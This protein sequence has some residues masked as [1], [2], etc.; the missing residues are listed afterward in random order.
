MVYLYR[1]CVSSKTLRIQRVTHPLGGT[2][3]LLEVVPIPFPRTLAMLFITCFIKRLRVI[4]SAWCLWKRSFPKNEG[5]KSSWGHLF[6]SSQVFSWNDSL[7][8]WVGLPDGQEKVSSTT[9]TE[10]LPPGRKHQNGRDAFLPPHIPYLL[11]P[12][13][14]F[15]ELIVSRWYHD[16]CMN[17]DLPSLRIVLC[18]LSWGYFLINNN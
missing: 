3:E 13:I 11:F 2:A 17:A 5:K 12:D 8:L 1:K 15:N 14:G 18:S 4:K 7:L 9:L 10:L 16:L 6:Y